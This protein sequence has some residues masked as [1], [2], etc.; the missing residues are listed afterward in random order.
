[1]KNEKEKEAKY[2]LTS[3]THVCVYRVCVCGGGVLCVCGGVYLGF[4]GDDLTRDLNCWSGW[5][6]VPCLFNFF[7]LL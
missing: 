2:W 4:I 1:M 6:I 3:P 5:F 7:Y